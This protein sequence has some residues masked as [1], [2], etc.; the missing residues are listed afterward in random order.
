M[1][2]PLTGVPHV[3][4][5]MTHKYTVMP[6][7]SEPPEPQDPAHYELIKPKVAGSMAGRKVCLELNVQPDIT[8]YEF[9]V[10]TA[11]LGGLVKGNVLAC[12]I[13]EGVLRHFKEVD[14]PAEIPD[15]PAMM[16]EIK[17]RR[18]A[19]VQIEAQKTKYF[20][21]LRRKAD[22]LARVT[23]L[24][25]KPMSNE[26]LDTMRHAMQSIAEKAGFNK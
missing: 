20:E 21:D 8:P 9:Y 26:M 13:Y 12:V 6:E 1:K 17:A 15:V 10:V 5:N 3:P 25:D 22:E 14:I 23:L 11:I 24:R 16:D 19:T 18:A 4:I 2:E 7:P